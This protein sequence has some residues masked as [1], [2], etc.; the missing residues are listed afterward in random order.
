MSEIFDENNMRQ[1]LGKYIPGGE[2][3]VA[4]GGSQS[5]GKRNLSIFFA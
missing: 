2:S 1:V 5:K 4:G 3:L